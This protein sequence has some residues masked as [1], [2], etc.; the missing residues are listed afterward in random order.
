MYNSDFLHNNWQLLIL[1]N[2][3]LAQ[4]QKNRTDIF[5]SM[6]VRLFNKIRMFADYV[7]MLVLRGIDELLLLAF[8]CSITAIVN[9]AL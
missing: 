2:L 9:E 8:A 6:D 5:S 7:I 1:P 3:Y 4:Q